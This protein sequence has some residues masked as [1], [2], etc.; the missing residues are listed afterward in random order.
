MIQAMVPLA[1]KAQ[2]NL[3]LYL[4]LDLDLNQSLGEEEDV[5]W[6]LGWA[7]ISAV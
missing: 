1:S 6:S 3:G 5:V 2:R 7:A 4:D